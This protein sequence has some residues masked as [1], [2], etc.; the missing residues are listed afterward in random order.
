M[1]V[2][3]TSRASFHSLISDLSGLRQEVYLAIK[4]WP[5]DRP[6]P[7]IEDLAN[8]LQRKESSMSGRVNELKQLGLIEEGPMKINA[9]R[10]SAMTYRAIAFK[11]QPIEF[12]PTFD[13]HGQGELFGI[14]DEEVLH[15]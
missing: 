8:L 3:Y 1:P 5:G 4:A 11:N 14:P 9:T 10:K 13:N 15:N 12:A 2:R 6:G 7:S